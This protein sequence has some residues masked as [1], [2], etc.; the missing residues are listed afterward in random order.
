[1]TKDSPGLIEEILEKS[2]PQRFEDYISNI[3]G[4]GRLLQALYNTPLESRVLGISR[5]LE[6][7][8][9]LL[10]KI[11]DINNN[12]VND[13]WRGFSK[14]QLMQIFGGWFAWN[15]WSVT[16]VEP[17]KHQFNHLIS[18]IDD[19]LNKEDRFSLEFRLFL[20]CSILASDD[21]VSFEEFKLLLD[22]TKSEDLSLFASMAMHYRRLLDKLSEKDRNNEIFKKIEKKIEGKMHNLGDI[23][24][25]VN[26]SINRQLKK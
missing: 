5:G 2:R 4:I 20:I 16:L 14:Y 26:V 22:K 13:L 23:A 18:H 8:N 6:N 11:L 12:D 3:G 25:L 19:K 9:C 24:N 21:F 15:N 7:T 10:Q 1:M 17:L